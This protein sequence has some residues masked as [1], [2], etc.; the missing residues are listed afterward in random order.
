MSGGVVL[1]VQPLTAVAFAPYGQVIALGGSCTRQIPI[2]D[3]RCMRHHDLAR[4]F[5]AG[6]GAVAFSLFDAAATA[7]PARLTLMERHRLGS[8]SFAPFGAALQLVAVVADAAIAP[9]ALGPE[10]LR[11]FVTDGQQGLQLAPGVWHHPLLSLQAGPWLVADR[12]AAEA[13]C[14]VVRIDGW[15]V[16]CS[17]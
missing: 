15:G 4:P 11:A 5:A 7:L 12:I 13:D 1:P 9:E 2:N 8:Q 10:H 14:D 3:G 16:H 6:P 17:G